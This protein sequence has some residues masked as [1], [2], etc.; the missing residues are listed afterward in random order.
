MD[1]NRNR[2]GS[3]TLCLHHRESRAGAHVTLNEIV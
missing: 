2:F 3:G 1:A